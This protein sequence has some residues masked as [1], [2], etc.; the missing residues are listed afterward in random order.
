MTTSRLS[1][2]LLSRETMAK[3][4]YSEEECLKALRAAISELGEAPTQQQYRSLELKPSAS[5]ISKTVGSWD[6]AL[7]KLGVE[8]ESRRQTSKERCLNSIRNLAEDLEKVPVA[9]DY[10]SSSYSP[11]ITTIRAHFG[12]WTNA[13]E[14]AGVDEFEEKSASEEANDLFESM[15]DAEYG[16][17]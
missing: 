14:E 7:R 10:E 17:K 8:K 13:R 16:K 3:K 12:T 5:T 15:E 2:A 11:S 9:N 4:S 6:L 1:T